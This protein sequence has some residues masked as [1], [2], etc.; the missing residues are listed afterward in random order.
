MGR[1]SRDELA[2]FFFFFLISVITIPS[3]PIVLF[4]IGCRNF[5]AV[6]F[7]SSYGILRANHGTVE[8]SFKLLE[9]TL[10]HLYSPLLTYL[11]STIRVQYAYTPSSLYYVYMLTA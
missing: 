5:C 4:L 7:S 9:L 8:I 2:L 6:E 11:G 1:G 10:L 3:F